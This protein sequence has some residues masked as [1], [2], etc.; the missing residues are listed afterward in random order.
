MSPI[1]FGCGLLVPVAAGCG[2]DDLASPTATEPIDDA[3]AVTAPAEVPVTSAP[4]TDATAPTAPATR[5]GTVTVDGSSCELDDDDFQIC[6]TVNPAFDDA[7]NVQVRF[8]VEPGDVIILGDP[9]QSRMS[10]G[11]IGDLPDDV[12]VD[13]GDAD[14][15]ANPAQ[16]VEVVRDGRTVS[17]TAT[18]VD[19]RV[20]ASVTE[21]SP[22][23]DTSIEFSVNC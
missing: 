5:T 13:A 12:R 17:G 6:E 4:V 20:G 8:D 9:V 10:L 2:S 23:R 15:F 14:L 3:A 18:I 7:I 21:D 16:A 1:P 11:V 19:D 22:L